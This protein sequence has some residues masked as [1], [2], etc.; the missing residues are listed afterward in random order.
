MAERATGG[1]ERRAPDVVN[2]HQHGSGTQ[3]VASSI[4]VVNIGAGRPPQD[5]LAAS[6]LLRR[7]D[8]QAQLGIR[9]RRRIQVRWTPPDDEQLATDHPELVWG[10]G[11]A[12]DLTGNLDEIAEVYERIPTGRL[13]VLGRAG[14]G[15]SM[16]GAQFVLRWLEKRSAGAPVSEI[17]SLGSWN[18]AE[19][20]LAHWL[21]DQLSR[22]RPWLAAAH[23]DGGMTL[24]ERLVSE[25]LVLPVLDGFDEI[26]E[27]LRDDARKKLSATWL[28]YV[29]TSRYDEYRKAVE[30]TTGLQ[31][32]AVVVLADLPPDDSVRYLRFSSPQG[33]AAGW[34]TVLADMRDNPEGPLRKALSTPLM[35]A[36]AAAVHGERG[37]SG[38]ET[39]LDSAE[40]PTPERLERHLL[41]A[42]LP[43]V[44]RRPSQARRAR[45]WLAHL[46]DDLRR[47]ETPTPDLAWWEL[48]TTL[49]LRQRTAVIAFLAGL[50]FA[51]VTAVGNIPVDLVA[52]SHGLG[53]ALRRGLV[54]GTL[55]GLLLGAA[56]G[57]IYHRASGND[58]LKPSP[59]EI[60]LRR[61]AGR[62]LREG[63]SSRI[64]VGSLV[65]LAGAV[66]IVAV[67]RSVVPWLGLDD[68]LGGGLVSAAQL[69]LIF[70]LGTGLV[71]AVTA[72]LE[73]PVDVDRSASCVDLLRMNR[74]NVHA[75]IAVWALVFGFIAWF[76]GSFTETPLRSLQ[77]GLVFGIEGAFGGGLGYGLCLTAW[78]QWI[79]LARI[80][81]PLTGRLPWRLVAFLE[82]ACER[83][84]LR[85]AGAVYQFRHARLQDHLAENPGTQPRP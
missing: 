10:D 65:A 25:R 7:R 38:P 17:F 33:A 53:F 66:A 42:F 12:R 69:P 3:V 79:A 81:L 9:D 48:G 83:R 11:P 78:G 26:P 8:E 6:V 61:D 15:K 31:G 49:P 73:A 43:S 19:V 1:G 58:A 77:L 5:E 82:D 71:L 70:G 14:S 32:A 2:A 85:R 59:I 29:L 45:R 40:F 80:W 67:D 60:T 4:G 44:Y 35:V 47:R 52:T 20:E 63:L 21:S 55:H 23:P 57:F 28:P 75:H 50:S 56:C 18:P 37:T 76:G 68:G 64:A 22:D 54:V 16:L 34:D 27:G 24:A 74:R 84:A 62:R 41:T 36:L 72:W 51:V 30:D 46:A 39:L 13:V